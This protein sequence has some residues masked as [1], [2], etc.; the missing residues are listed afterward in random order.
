[1]P[2]V[3]PS[4]LLVEGDLT[5]KVCSAVLSLVFINALFSGDSDQTMRPSSPTTLL[6]YAEAAQHG[7]RAGA[8]TTTGAKKRPD[9]DHLVRERLL[10]NMSL[11]RFRTKCVSS[12]RG[13]VTCKP[14]SLLGRLYAVKRERE[15]HAITFL[16]KGMT[17][18]LTRTLLLEYELIHGPEALA[19]RKRE[20]L[21]LSIVRALIRAV[22]GR[23]INLRSAV[24]PPGLW[25]ARNNKG[26]L[27]LSECGGFRNAAAALVDGTTLIPF[28]NTARK[29]GP[30]TQTDRGTCPGVGL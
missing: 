23:R 12:L 5:G 27:A 22:D 17:H 30:H 10:K 19:P 26:A 25:L 13:R 9:P 1:M 11:L 15:K 16:T 28:M 3:P 6:A 4:T 24:V 20:A 2:L 7:M 21:T 18:Q 14:E 29:L 8:P